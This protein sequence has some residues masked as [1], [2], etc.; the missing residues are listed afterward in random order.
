M[1]FRYFRFSE[2]L[3]TIIN[4]ELNIIASPSPDRSGNP[5]TECNEVKDCSGKREIASNEKT[6]RSALQSAR[7]APNGKHRAG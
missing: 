1:G 2:T 7:F 4:R 5:F 6:K 3:S